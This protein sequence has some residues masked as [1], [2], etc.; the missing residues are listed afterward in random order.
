MPKTRRQ[1]YDAAFKL[2]AIAIALEKGNRAAAQELGINESMVRRWRIQQGELAKCKKSK[3]AF[4]GCKARWPQLENELED[5]VNT[6]RADGRGVST[7]QLRLKARTVASHL[8]LADFKGG[9][10]WC[11]RFMRRKGLT[12]RARTTLCQQLP[13][14]FEEKLASF[15]NYTQEQVAENLIGPQDIINMDEVPLTFD[16][17]LTRT[18]NKQGESSVPLKTTGHE[19]TH[20]TCILSCTASGEKL[21]PMVIFKRITMPK[22]KLPKGIVVRVN[23]KGWMDEKM[24]ETWL[25]ECY[26]KRPGGFFRRNKALLVMDSIRAHITQTIK[27]A[28]TSTNA[29]NAIIPGGTTKYLQPLDISVNRPFKLKMR[30]EWEKWM[31]EGEKSFTKT[32]RMRRATFAEV[33]QW[34]LTAWGAIKKSTI[35][36]GFKKA[37]I[38]EADDTT[39]EATGAEEYSE[40]D[41]DTSGE[42]TDSVSEAIL[43]LFVSATE[44]SDFSGF[45]EADDE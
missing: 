7:V 13:P 44:E 45:S 35:T 20:F 18:V 39:Q 12:I 24:M 2:N 3:K 15:Q 21:P 5:W 11:C 4:R 8:A 10:S 1:A 23:K 6:Q 40:S 33:C 9:Q 28:V 43:N 29:I 19:K 26:G 31:T 32:G 38:I 36:N 37:G 25:T 41:C 34:I 17:P 42:D 16:L 22:E 30:N 27:R 14:D